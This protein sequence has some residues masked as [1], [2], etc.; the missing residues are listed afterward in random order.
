MSEIQTGISKAR[1]LI[2][3][4]SDLIDYNNSLVSIVAQSMESEV[5]IGKQ[6]I[7]DALLML[8]VEC[9]MS[10]SLATLASKVESL[11]QAVGDVTFTDDVPRPLDMSYFAAMGGCDVITIK[12]ESATKV[13]N[14]AYYQASMLNSVIAKN[15]EIIGSYAFYECINLT[16]IESPQTNE[17]GYYAFYRCTSLGSINFPLVTD[18]GIYGFANCTSL[19]EVVL[20]KVIS[21]GKFGLASCTSLKKV[22]LPKLETSGTDFFNGD[23]KLEEADLS[24]LTTVEARMFQN[25]PNLIDLTIGKNFTSNVSLGLIPTNAMKK[26]ISTLCYDT[27]IDKYGQVFVSNWDKWKWCI[28]NHFAANLPDRTGLTAFTITF[29]STTLNNFDEEMKLAFTNKNW[30]L[31]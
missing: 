5:A 1:T 16:N 6:E 10:D 7:V 8:G 26:T 17:I 22:I 19:T 20:P 3:Q 15:I 18:I 29:G 13:R 25:C 21:F 31:A 28:I 24:S 27:D 4:N 9:S 14:K 23:S 12:D 2:Q 30:T 11:E